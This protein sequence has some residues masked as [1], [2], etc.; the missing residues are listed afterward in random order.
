VVTAGGLLAK[1]LR[2]DGDYVELEL[3]PNVRVRA[4]KMTIGD[5]VPPQS[6]AND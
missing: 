6:A 1:V 5:V 3:G 4:V 2:V